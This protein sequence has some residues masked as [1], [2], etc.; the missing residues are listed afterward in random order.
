M[1]ENTRKYL[2][3]A[4]L[5]I[6]VFV[7]VTAKNLRTQKQVE[8]LADDSIVGKGTPVLLELGSHG[9]IPC[10]K[11]MP[12]LIELSKEQTDFE[13]S[14][15]DIHA[16]D[17]KAKQYGIEL[18]PT[19]I[20]FDAEGKEVFRHTGFFGKDKILAKWKELQAKAE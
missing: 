4:G 3:I 8:G 18:I 17:G 9:C 13:V 12:I 15:I 5:F 1:K 19:Q 20:F 16:V 6:A 11:M 14:F 2:I 7:L 10:D